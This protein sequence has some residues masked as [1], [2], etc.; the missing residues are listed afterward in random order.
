MADEERAAPAEF[1]DVRE[2]LAAPKKLSAFEKERLAAQEK[3]RREAAENE[4]A[5]REFQDSLGGDEED[6][7]A[8]DGFPRFNKPPAAPQGGFGGLPSRY[9]AS[10]PRSGPGCLGPVAGVVP[11]NLKRKRA[12]DEMREAQEARREQEDL[13]AFASRNAARPA[14]DSRDTRDRDEEMEQEVAPRPTVQLSSLPPMTRE[15]DVKALLGPYLQVHSVRLQPPPRTE[16]GAK[17]SLTAIAELSSETSTTH[18]DAAVS[19]LKDKYLSAGFYLSISRHLLS[20]SWHGNLPS[21]PAATSAEPFGAQKVNK[22]QPARFNMRNAPPPS[23]FAPPDSY[24]APARPAISANATIHVQPPVDIATLRAAHTIVDRL[25]SEPDASR[26]LEIEAMLM[27][28]P[29]VQD[30]ERFAFLYNSRS[31]AGVYYRFLLWGDGNGYDSIQACKRAAQGPERILDDVIIDWVPPHEEVPFADLSSLG[32]VIDHSNYESSEEDSDDEERRHF[33]Q[34]GREGQGPPP[35]TERKHLT[36][37]QV[38]KFAWLLSRMPSSHTKLRKAEVGAV[39]SFAIN[40]AGAGAEEIVDMLVLNVEKPFTST[41]CAR[42]EKEDVNQDEDDMYEPDEELPTLETTSAP[43]AGKTGEEKDDPSLAKLVA[44]YLINDV[45][46]NSSTAGVRN[47]WKYRQLFENAFKRQKTFEHLGQLEKDLGWGRFRAEQWRGRIRGLFEV[48][49]KG[50]VFA[51]DVFEQL[52]KNFFEQPVQQ[53][54]EAEKAAA[55]SKKLEEKRMARFKRVDGTGTPADSESPAPAAASSNV[56]GEPLE[57]L[58]GAP[59]DDLDGIPMDDLDGAP[60]EDLDGLPASDARM[61][62]APPAKANPSTAPQAQ[63]TKGGISLKS[64]SGAKPPAT[65]PKRRKLA[66]DMFA[67]SDE[68]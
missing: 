2:K 6:E 13:A 57:D 60:L 22:D 34:S 17:R 3:K 10:G 33:N 42:F 54:E 37:L 31:T 49:E 47:A 18:I 66:E 56:D 68:E 44:L 11:P 25:L 61:T 14:Q 21:V 19:A 16:Y 15:E 65:G 58:D 50:S 46:H 35:P 55:D 41:Q 5:L 53:D 24:D 64:S 27:S 26:A 28:L 36:P 23:D 52:K 67:D 62:D 32:E 48:W 51:S 39:T 43:D 4:K 63:D 9:G 45:L 30:D 20:T 38:A 59:M 8:F 40:N 12:L 1:P 29:E 7:D